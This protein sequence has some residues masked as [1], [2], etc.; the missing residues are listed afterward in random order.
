VRRLVGE[1]R[2]DDLRRGHDEREAVRVGG[3]DGPGEVDRT[4]QL[5]G[6]GIV[7][8]G[9]RRRPAVH[10][11]LEVLG[12]EDLQRVIEHEGGAERVGPG[13]RLAPQR[14][15]LQMDPLG[16]L[17]RVGVAAGPE[18]EALA[19]GDRHDLVG[20]LGDADEDALDDVQQ[21]GE[22]VS[23]EQPAGLGA[24]EHQRRTLARI[25]AGGLG[26]LPRR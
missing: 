15:G 4:E 25:D 11:L 6:L 10:A 24:I 1:V 16:G 13:H 19:V 2:L 3:V 17:Q 22:R 23:Q 8:R 18:D 21:R 12:G 14:T 9:R 20:V 5:T 26:A 7:D